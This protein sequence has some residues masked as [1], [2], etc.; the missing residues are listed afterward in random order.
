MHDEVTDSP[1][2]KSQAVELATTPTN[3][4]L[5]PPPPKKSVI[6]TEDEEPSDWNTITGV[7]VEAEEALE[8]EIENS[9]SALFAGERTSI[10]KTITNLWTGNPANFLPLEYPSSASEHFFPDSLIVVR[11]EEPSSIIAFTLG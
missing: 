3:N 8:E 9:D 2:I 7:S 6:S 1:S 4:V 10:M 5:S 11:E